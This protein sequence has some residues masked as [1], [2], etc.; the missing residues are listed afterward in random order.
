MLSTGEAIRRKGT[1]TFNQYFLP[2]RDL[3]YEETVYLFRGLAMNEHTTRFTINAN[4]K[5]IFPE[6]GQNPLRT[7]S[8]DPG[9][10]ARAAFNDVYEDIDAWVEDV[11]DIDVYDLSGSF[12]FDGKWTYIEIQKDGTI[13]TLFRK[14]RGDLLKILSDA[15]VVAMAMSA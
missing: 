4:D 5:R 11:K 10:I 6:G 1:D 8:S 12:D 9:I 3:T 15:E 14:D 7:L 13:R 2:D